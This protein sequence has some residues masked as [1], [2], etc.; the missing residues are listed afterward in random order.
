[1]MTVVE[2]LF[3]SPIVPATAPV[4]LRNANPA[5]GVA[6]IGVTDPSSS[7]FIPIGGVVLPAP[8]GETCIVSVTDCAICGGHTVSPNLFRHGSYAPIEK[9]PTGRGTPR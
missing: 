8:A 3:E 6:V 1:M 7:L 2:A 4:Q 9:P 5:L